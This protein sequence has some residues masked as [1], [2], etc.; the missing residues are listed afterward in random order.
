MQLS[1]GKLTLLLVILF[2]GVTAATTGVG[3]YLVHDVHDTIERRYATE[4]HAAV[5]NAALAVRNQVKFYQ[6]IAQQTSAAPDVSDLLEFGDGAEVSAWSQRLRQLLPGTLGA[7]LASPA[8]AVHGDP[9]MQRIGPSCESDMRHVVTGEPIDYPPLHTDVPGLEHF[10]VITRVRS[11][12][13]DA[14]GVVFISF[15]LDVIEK[16]LRGSLGT[17]DTFELL[18]RSGNVHLSTASGK[19]P[20][21]TRRFAA[22]I[23]GTSWQL[24]L[25]RSPPASTPI[26]STLLG[27]DALILLAVGILALYLG[28]RMLSAFRTDIRRVHGGLK[29]LLDGSYRPSTELTELRETGELLQQM[30]SLALRLRDIEPNPRRRSLSDPLTGVYNRHYFDLMIAHLHEQSHHRPPA[31]VVVIDVDE[32]KRI[33]TEHDHFFGDRVLQFTAQFLLARIRNTDIVARVVGDQFAVILDHREYGTLDQWLKVTAQSYDDA[34]ASHDEFHNARCHLS[35][36]ATDIDAALHAA[37]QDVLH[38]ADQAIDAARLHPSEHSRYCI[39]STGT[40]SP[41]AG[42]PAVRPAVR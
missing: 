20:G 5:T 14:A 6:E 7:A 42:A 11:P 34:V 38:A 41:L 22:E 37:P 29:S 25:Y 16:V 23:P 10:D 3:L 17:D 40:A 35:M 24:V 28:R 18:D 19:N 32:L 30:D 33:N 1:I 36:G 26:T 15:H 27:I 39:W 31:I 9:L 8:G 21:D 4:A 13:G 12:N 2:V